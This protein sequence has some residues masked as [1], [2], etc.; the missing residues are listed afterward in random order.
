MASTA[1]PIK[2]VIVMIADGAGF[3]TLQATRLYLQGLADG[4]PRAAVSESGG[5]AHATSAS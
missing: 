2:N 3:N 4:D 5:E 1:G